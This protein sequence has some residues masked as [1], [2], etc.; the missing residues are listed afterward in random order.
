MKHIDSN[1][2]VAAAADRVLPKPSRRIRMLV[3]RALR[4]QERGKR[5]FDMASV[6][7]QMA[8]NAGLQVGQEVEVE[9]VDENGEKKTESFSLHD[10]F[11]GEVAY[12]PA[13]IPHFELKRIPKYKREPKPDP[14]T[15]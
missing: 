10:N 15:A 2:A 13:R 12:R 11:T 4:Y 3:R 7:L 14:E 8:R 1:G 9:L 6:A 5:L